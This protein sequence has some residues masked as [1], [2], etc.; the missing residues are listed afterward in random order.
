[1][2]LESLPNECLLRLLGFISTKTLGRITQV[3]HKLHD[4]IDNDDYLWQSRCNEEFAP[5][6]IEKFE[7]FVKFPF[8]KVKDIYFFLLRPFGKLL[9][10]WQADNPFY[11]GQMISISPDF[12]SGAI[13]AYRITT[14]NALTDQGR[15]DERAFS[16][17][18]DISVDSF[19]VRVTKTKIFEIRF[20]VV[21]GVFTGQSVCL[22]G[23]LGGESVSE[24]SLAVSGP[25]GKLR[26]LAPSQQTGLWPFPQG[27]PLPFAYMVASRS[28]SSSSPTSFGQS[29]DST[30]LSLSC[31]NDCYT[32][33]FSRLFSLQARR[34]LPSNLQ[35]NNFSQIWSKIKFSDAAPSDVPI[36]PREG[37]WTG[38]YSTHGLEILLFQYTTNEENQCCLEAH[39]ITG[40]LNVPRGELSWKTQFTNPRRTISSEAGQFHVTDTTE[41]NDDKI[42]IYDGI[43]KIAMAGYQGVTETPAE[44][45]IVSEEEVYVHWKE[46][47]KISLF[48]R[49]NSL[50]P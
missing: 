15:A 14:R 38:S 32:Y 30:L 19:E 39:K 13:S 42:M 11:M 18:G 43:G 21:D 40:D 24:H 1:M 46:L 45:I 41:F 33:N 6:R 50:Y 29:P 8:Q 26:E 23:K 17:Y 49:V 48:Q 31:T 2:N 37:I 16:L 35:N 9:G 10:L 47:F 3:S 28:S 36:A 22:G 7:N 4:L 27:S 12:E 5:F 25:Q 44:V 20:E 34:A